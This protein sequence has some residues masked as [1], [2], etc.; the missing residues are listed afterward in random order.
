[1][2]KRAWLFTA[3]LFGLLVIIVACA[4][5]ATIEAPE[6][7]MERGIYPVGTATPIAMGGLVAVRDFSNPVAT[8]V[9][10]QVGSHYQI[11]WNDVQANLAATPSWSAVNTR[12]AAIATAGMQAWLSVA[13]YEAN[14]AVTPAATDIVHV[15]VGVATVNYTINSHT[16][17]GPNYG[18]SIFINSYD[19]MVQSL[20]AQFDTDPNVAGFI[21]ELGID[22]EALNTK[23]SPIG[24]RTAFET[25]VSCDSYVEWVKRAM[26]TYRRFTTKPLYIKT[27]VALC[28][29]NPLNAANYRSWTG[30]NKV[31]M[32]YSYA[33][34]P[35][36]GAPNPYALPT[37]T[38]LWIGFMNAGIGANK[39]DAYAWGNA[40]G[41][42]NLQA[43]QRMD[44]IG[45]AAFEPG[46]FPASIATASVSGYA[47]MMAW[48]MLGPGRADNLFLQS[49]WFPY[50]TANTM[51]A[52]TMT[53]GSGIDNSRAAYAS[54]YDA[55]WARTSG[56]TGYSS[57]PGPWTHLA[58]VVVTSQPT[59][60]CSPSILATVQHTSQVWSSYLTPAPC[61]ASIST[62]S[63]A[64]SYY[65]YRFGASKQV[66]INLSDTW[67]NRL[68]LPQ[69]ATMQ[70][71]YL[72]NSG[73]IGIQYLNA[74]G[75]ATASIVK[76]NTNTWKTASIALSD[77]RPS[78]GANIMDIIIT[79][80]TSGDTFQEV[81]IEFPA[82]PVAASTPTPVLTFTPVPASSTP[83]STAT[84]VPSA[85]P[86]PTGT[87][88]DTPTSTPSN[89]P[90][91]T[92]TLT[93]SP[94]PTP[95]ATRPS[96]TV[97]STAPPTATGEPRTSLNSP[98]ET[99][100]PENWTGQVVSNAAISTVVAPNCVS[101]NCWQW[102]QDNTSNGIAR[103]YNDVV[104]AYR[105]NLTPNA[106]LHMS[107][108]IKVVETPSAAINVFNWYDV[109][110]LPSNPILKL[111]PRSAG[112]P[113]TLQT[114]AD[115]ATFSWDMTDDA[116]HTVD[117]YADQQ[118]YNYRL[119]RV[120]SRG[121]VP[122]AVS[123]DG[124][125]IP[126]PTGFPLPAFVVA[127]DAVGTL[128]WHGEENEATYKYN[129][130]SVL[131]EVCKG[132]TGV[133]QTPTPNTPIAVYWTVTPSSTP[134]PTSIASVVASYTPSSTPTASDTPSP[135]PSPTPSS[136]PV[137]VAGGGNYN[138]I[139]NS[140]YKS[141]PDG[142]YT[143][144]ETEYV[145][146]ANGE[147]NNALLLW[148]SISIPYSAT[149]VVTATITLYPT[150]LLGAGSNYVIPV[151]L[152]EMGRA[153]NPELVTW[154]D[155]GVGA[156]FQ[157]G[158]LGT[159]DVRTG[160]TQHI[161]YVHSATDPIV[162]DVT[163][164]VR[165][166]LFDGYTNF[167]WRARILN[168]GTTSWLGVGFASDRYFDLAR[169]PVLDM[170]FGYPATVTPTPTPSNTPT[171]PPSATP[172]PPTPTGTLTPTMTPSP[173]TTP[174]SPTPTRMPW[175]GIQINEVC[176]A[177]SYDFNLD[178]AV[179]SDDRYI[180]L[181]N[182]SENNVDM[183]QGRLEFNYSDTYGVATTK[184]F[185]FPRG[186]TMYAEAMK[187]IF[188]EDLLNTINATKFTMPQAAT[189]SVYDAGGVL[190]DTR[191][192]NYQGNNICWLF[193]NNIWTVGSPS[194]GY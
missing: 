52:I 148:P 100:Y 17:I 168:P 28:G 49:Q 121:E 22:G 155:S 14:T 32:E 192:Y 131:V 181:Y 175:T 169:R 8:P 19:D 180:E 136:T 70:L 165:R 55:P 21:L 50:L 176:P 59:R 9:S 153:W 132:I 118:P 124:T 110:A 159:G 38:P 96:I 92:G 170:Q 39:Q 24:S 123:V 143:S 12:V 122:F 101:G 37:A 34:S 130:D 83:T 145:Q 53:A 63:G 189:V 77:F 76:T 139:T 99:A 146:W 23:D 128:R 111:Q 186:A 51:Y 184:T 182:G 25:E 89:T 11:Y 98:M 125:P 47:N 68:T 149:H 142:N 58:T 127:T 18:S 1:M 137:A 174:P 84:S 35:T 80:G 78:V 57:A 113:W 61:V 162:I 16:D 163:A 75:I 167:G 54:F 10:G 65:A 46:L 26:N 43:G 7:I 93:A 173:T 129:V 183:Y 188:S 178:G 91:P 42:G 187:V 13:F 79:T 6:P 64:E 151:E 2:Q 194:P 15:P 157:A 126:T 88:T 158:A 60:V 29:S 85:V 141:L 154:N 69:N 190:Q 27:G 5:P 87:L 33:A 138:S 108:A 44:N 150:G 161:A 144:A 90:S 179:S 172:K 41:W 134:S 119:T 166:L 103:V 112:D 86:S 66:A 62:P 36:P 171:T 3:I 185:I 40:D 109:G 114:G 45:G 177:P 147:I 4:R 140:I 94:T 105:P 20:M 82:G 104:T 164:S 191:Y 74:T 67:V 193:E 156:W 116:W 48:S 152:V 120:P 31:L 95:S 72:D 81:F 107:F 106:S 117:I 30:S 133:C 160:S 102:S 97:T 115:N 135:T 73:T 56:G 71:V